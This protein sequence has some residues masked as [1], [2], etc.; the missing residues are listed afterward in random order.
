MTWRTAFSMETASASKPREKRSS[1]ATERIWAMGLAMP[2]PAMS[3]A[4]PPLGSKRPKYSPSP[5][6]LPRLALASMPRLPQIMAISSLRISPNKFSVT[7][8]SKLRGALMSCM[9]A[10]STYRWASV[11]SGYSLAISIMVSRQSTEFVRTL[12]LSTLVTCLLRS[13]AALKATCPMRAIS[14]FL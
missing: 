6:G 3:G 1:R 5:F 8:T 4:V 12:A 14:L 2:R 9:A 13:C 7:M 11:T 10:L